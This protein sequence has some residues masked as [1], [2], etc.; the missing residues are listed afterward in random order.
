MK[1]IFYVLLLVGILLGLRSNASAQK[2][3]L[4]S[5][6]QMAEDFAIL[7]Q[8]L[9]ALHPGLYLYNTKAQVEKYF[10]DFEAGIKFRQPLSLRFA[11]VPESNP[12]LIEARRRR[13][14]Q[15]GANR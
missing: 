4:L 3:V 8:S 15:P 12:R 5:P 13:S 6:Q 11:A 9:V 7:K 14:R 10:S 1:K 2:E